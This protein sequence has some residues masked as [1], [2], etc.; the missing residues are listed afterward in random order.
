MREAS[1]KGQKSLEMET[2]VGEAGKGR[3]ER[4]G[5]RRGSRV[6]QCTGLLKRL[7]GRKLPLT[8]TSQ[9]EFTE[10]VKVEIGAYSLRE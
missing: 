10:Q 9:E 7:Q 2:G 3:R 8:G 4:E 5:A 1:G 6:L